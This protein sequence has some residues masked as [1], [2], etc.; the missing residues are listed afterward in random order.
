MGGLTTIRFD[1]RCSHATRCRNFNARDQ[2]ARST[3]R[4]ATSPFMMSNNAG[5]CVGLDVVSALSDDSARGV[6]WTRVVASVRRNLR[7]YFLFSDPTCARNRNSHGAWS[8]EAGRFSDDSRP[9]SSLW[10]L[11]ARNRDTCR[12]HSRAACCPPLAPALWRRRN[13]PLT[14]V[15][16]RSV[17]TAVAILACYIPARRAMRVDPM[18][19]LRYE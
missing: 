17:L 6:C 10:P 7:S 11:L 19:A 9:R 1:G 2:S 18:V 5:V 15:C 12:A 13:D 8:T 3:E 16:H 4:A 14:I